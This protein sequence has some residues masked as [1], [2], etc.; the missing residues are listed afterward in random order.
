VSLTTRDGNPSEI[1]NSRKTW[2][3]LWGRELRSLVLGISFGKILSTYL[4]T[5]KQ[6]A[7]I[8]LISCIWLKRLQKRSFPKMWHISHWNSILARIQ[9]SLLLFEQA[10]GYEEGIFQEDATQLP[11]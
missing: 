5:P 11:Q 9:G 8:V 2:W 6:F 10:P 1:T 4:M 7:T 3:L